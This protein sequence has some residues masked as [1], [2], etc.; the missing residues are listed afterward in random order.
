MKKLIL[1]LI[2][3][4]VLALASEF[5]LI[6]K[7]GYLFIP[8]GFVRLDC[9]GEDTCAFQ[10][11]FPDGDYL[12]RSDDGDSTLITVNDTCP[13]TISNSNIRINQP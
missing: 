8:K 5:V 12:Y 10:I 9:K 4:P 7:P 2:F 6:C 3:V 13:V 1:L 11:D